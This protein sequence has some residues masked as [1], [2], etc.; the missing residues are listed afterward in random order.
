MTPH[1]PRTGVLLK[2]LEGEL[3]ASAVVINAIQTHH[4]PTTTSFHR[5]DGT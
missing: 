3:R 4:A 5:R 1:W 2:G